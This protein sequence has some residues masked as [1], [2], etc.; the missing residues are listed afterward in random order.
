MPIPQHKP[1]H[2]GA[3]T[4]KMKVFYSRSTN[5][6]VPAIFESHSQ[7]AERTQSRGPRS[8]HTGAECHQVPPSA[9]RCHRHSPGQRCS[10]PPLL[11]HSLDLRGTNRGFFLSQDQFVV[12]IKP[13]APNC[14][15][16]SSI[17]LNRLQ[18]LERVLISEGKI[19]K[20]K[21]GI[22]A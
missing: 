8:E 12:L 10:N 5:L 16:F 15:F 3:F 14:F 13:P 6:M 4:I 19:Q 22:W 18:P 7:E 1:R 17:A 21:K 11:K 2:S 9:T 20:K